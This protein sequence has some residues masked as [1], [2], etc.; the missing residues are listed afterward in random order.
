MF[1]LCSLS[2]SHAFEISIRPVQKNITIDINP[3]IRC[4]YCDI[5]KYIF[6][7][8]HTL[9]GLV[10]NIDSHLVQKNKRDV[11]NIICMNIKPFFIQ[12]TRS[13]TLTPPL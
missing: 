8:L 4:T 12:I 5:A 11:F 2:T 6:S 7:L 1:R 10:T 13:V 9:V 3:T